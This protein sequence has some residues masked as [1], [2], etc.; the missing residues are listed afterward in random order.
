[1]LAGDPELAVS[2]SLSSSSEETFNQIK[3]WDNLCYDNHERCR[4]VV[5][6]TLTASTCPAGRILD[7]DPDPEQ[8]DAYETGVIR[9]VNGQDVEPGAKYITV[10]HCWG[11]Y[12]PY[13]LKNARLSTFQAGLHPRILAKTFIDAIDISRRLGVKYLWI[14]C[15]CIIQ[16]DKHDVDWKKESA[17]M[18]QIYAG[19]WLNIAAVRAQDARDGCY[20]NRESWDVS[21]LVIHLE[22]PAIRR[23][24]HYFVLFDNQMHNTDVL[25]SN[26]MQ[27]AWVQQEQ[28]FSRR[29]LYYAQHQVYWRCQELTACEK[30]VMELPVYAKGSTLFQKAYE[31]ASLD[32][33]AKIASP[34]LQRQFL[35]RWSSGKEIFTSH[36]DRDPSV[37]NPQR[38]IIDRWKANSALLEIWSAIVGRYSSCH[39]SRPA[40]DKLI[41]ISGLARRCGDSD[42]YLAGLWRS[43]LPWQLL[44]RAKGSTRKTRAYPR[45]PGTPSWSWA[46]VHQ[47]V[48]LHHHLDSRRYHLEDDQPLIEIHAAETQPDV[49]DPFGQVE[50]GTLTLTGSMLKLKVSDVQTMMEDW[51]RT[52]AADEWGRPSIPENWEYYVYC[53]DDLWTHLQDHSAYF[54]AVLKGKTNEHGVSIVV[55]QGLLLELT[56]HKRG[57]YRRRGSFVIPTGIAEIWP[58]E[59]KENLAN[60]LDEE[61]YDQCQGWQLNCDQ[62]SGLAFNRYRITI[63]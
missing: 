47:P 24:H 29:T 41:A 14:D 20:A 1:M 45:L 9:L 26:L 6:P 46:S 38:E 61:A 63:V 33:G 19:A 16:D 15:L 40:R 55:L 50:G 53:E 44:W 43:S 59:F 17:K 2:R 28:F 49:N 13:K 36:I 31:I 62:D 54:L 27:R 8:C 11:Y 23:P 48:K 12:K 32:A 22:F 52:S 7:L 3:A 18:A 42:D 51:S 56:G 37:H 57:E 34:D 58:G 4:S 10:S 30:F 39:L 35:N 25:H 60:V 5:P 21:P